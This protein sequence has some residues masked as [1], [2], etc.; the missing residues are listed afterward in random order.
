MKRET[1]QTI[2]KRIARLRHSHGWTQE[3]LA[4]RIAISRVAVS[5]I[6]MDLST[7]SERTVALLAGVFKLSPQE[8]VAGTT[9]P[10]GK[11]D[12]LP[13]AVCC[14][15]ELELDLALLYNDLEWLERLA[16][17]CR[18][19]PRLAAAVHDRWLP[20]LAH[21]RHACVDAGERKRIETAR[22]A[23]HVACAPNEKKEVTNEH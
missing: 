13:A 11:S 9:Y 17:H 7:P 1:A 8:L 20:R 18:D 19:W 15:T 6:E 4:E 3:R 14:Y 23:L 10:Q 12:R 16:H 21:W 2:G 5:H 22:R